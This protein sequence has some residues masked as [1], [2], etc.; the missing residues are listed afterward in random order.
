MMQKS[1]VLVVIQEM[2]LR[3]LLQ[4]LPDVIQKCIA[5]RNVCSQVRGLHGLFFAASKLHCQPSEEGRG[6]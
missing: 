4:F 6:G 5:Q 1:L 2:A 3:F